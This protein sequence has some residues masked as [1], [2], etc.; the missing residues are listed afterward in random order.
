MVDIL[1]TS[2]AGF[3]TSMSL[4]LD[5]RDTYTQGHSKRVAQ[6]AE[7]IAHEMKLPADEIEQI[8]RGALL[9]DIGKI[10]ISDEIL[11]KPGRLNANEWILM[12]QHPEIGYE[13]LQSIPFLHSALD[14]VLYHHERFDGTGY[15]KGLKGTIIP[16]PA[17]IL[18]VADAYDAMTSNRPYRSGMPGT[19]ALNQIYILSGFQFDPVVVNAFERTL[20]SFMEFDIV[21]TENSNMV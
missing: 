7:N 11:H 20:P 4:T 9:H 10:G 14:A 17:R 1:E 15:P 18:A 13:M 6:L 21:L 3:L 2:Y 19:D 16:L 5:A 12:R 8:V